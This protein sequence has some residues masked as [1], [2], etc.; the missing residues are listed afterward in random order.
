MKQNVRSMVLF[1]TVT[2]VLGMFAGCKTAPPIDVLTTDLE[3]DDSSAAGSGSGDGLPPV[4]LEN[5]LFEPGSKY[6]LQTVYFDYNSSN[7]RSD[8]MA[9]LRENAEKIKQVPGV[10]IQVAGHCDSR[11]TQEYNLALGERRAL[12]VRQYLI[13]LGI[14]GDRLI[15]ISYGKEFPAAMGESEDAWSRNRRAEFNRAR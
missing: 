5:L 11:G 6:G 7:L 15:T 8:S 3:G 13:Q 14:P 12:A 4:D 2:A 10:M 9:T 1:L